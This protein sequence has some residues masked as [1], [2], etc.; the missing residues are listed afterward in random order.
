MHFPPVAPISSRRFR[1]HRDR[2]NEL[3]KVQSGPAFHEIAGL[4]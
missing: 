2:R 1:G 3:P 4:L